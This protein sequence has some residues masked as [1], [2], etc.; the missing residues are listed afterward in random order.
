MG[1]FIITHLFFQKSI[2]HYADYI[3]IY[4][5][6]LD[7]QIDNTNDKSKRLVIASEEKRFLR[8]IFSRKF[9][10]GLCFQKRLMQAAAGFM[11]VQDFQPFVMQ[12]FRA[13]EFDAGRKGRLCSRSEL[14]Q[15]SK[16]IG[17][18]YAK[19]AHYFSTGSQIKHNPDH[20]TKA[21]FAAHLVHILRDLKEDIQEGFINIPK[22]ELSAFRIGLQDL[23]SYEFRSWVR[24]RLRRAKKIFRES[25]KMAK[26]INNR[27]ER[28][29]FYI[30]CLRYEYVMN[31][32]KKDDYI[33]RR[34]YEKTFFDKFTFLMKVI[35]VM[36]QH[37]F[38]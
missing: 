18:S 36:V 3:Y 1:T 29:S 22:E 30:Y 10:K 9:Q 5:R 19:G 20:L 25:K 24:Y 34:S 11:K 35:G 15:Y 6:W 16:D 14:L 7:D 12:M 32:I 2:R 4:F 23:D 37:S 26:N 33:L 13:L 21:A 27:R 8:D 17:Y 38:R 28:I 31:K